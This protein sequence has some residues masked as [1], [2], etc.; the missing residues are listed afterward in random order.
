MIL[1]DCDGRGVEGGE[2]DSSSEKKIRFMLMLFKDGKKNQCRRNK[3]R[4]VKWT[5]GKSYLDLGRQCEW[6]CWLRTPELSVE[7]WRDAAVVAVVVAL[8]AEFFAME[9][10]GGWSAETCSSVDLPEVATTNARSRNWPT[11]VD[12]KNV[13]RIEDV[14]CS[15]EKSLGPGKTDK[16]IQYL[17]TLT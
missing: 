7:W 15:T 2:T 1:T 14:W 9:R 13:S 10:L 17:R 12:S 5:F 3:N 11:I 6:F 8:L 4:T 16:K